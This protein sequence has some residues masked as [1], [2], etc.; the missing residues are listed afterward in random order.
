MNEKALH[1]LEYDKIIEKV[2]RFPRWQRN[3][4]RHCAL[5]LP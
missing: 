3:V 5:L 2:M 1:T 4:P